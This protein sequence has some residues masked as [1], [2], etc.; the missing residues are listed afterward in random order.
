M[1]CAAITK[2]FCAPSD[3][4]IEVKRRHVTEDG[5][6]LEVQLTGTHSGSWRGLPATGRRFSF[7]LC[8]FF[9]FDDQD[10]LAGERIY[11][12]RATVLQQMGVLSEPTSLKGPL[13]RVASPPD[14]GFAS[15]LG[16]PA[17]QVK[18]RPQPFDFGD[19]S[20]VTIDLSSRDGRRTALRLTHAGL[21][22]SKLAA[23]MRMLETEA[24]RASATMS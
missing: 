7:P 14:H 24:R 2:T 10:R 8:A 12:D 9:T 13:G 23:G 17:R 6:V 18:A 1:R 19:Q 15:L 5:V 21:P 11:Y 22:D 20:V 4:H 3:F 16:D